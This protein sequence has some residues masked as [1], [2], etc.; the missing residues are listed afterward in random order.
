MLA[1]ALLRYAPEHK[2]SDLRVIHS[3]GI[4]LMLKFCRLAEQKYLVKILLFV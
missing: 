1:L 2:L 4:S 3:A